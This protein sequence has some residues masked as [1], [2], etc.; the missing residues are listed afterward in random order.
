MELPS[1][2]LLHLLIFVS[3]MCGAGVESLIK[4]T[5]MDTGNIWLAPIHRNSAIIIC[6]A[7]LDFFILSLIFKRGVGLVETGVMQVVYYYFAL[8]LFGWFCFG[9][10]LDMVKA[11]GMGLGLLSVI[12]MTWDQWSWTK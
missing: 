12:M 1:K 4:K 5:V 8:Q 9:E 3:S 10:R 7:A 2:V 11:A 6:V